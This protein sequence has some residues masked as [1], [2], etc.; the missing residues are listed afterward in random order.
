MQGAEDEE[1]EAGDE[2]SRPAASPSASDAAGEPASE[3]GRG[4]AGDAPEA[5]AATDSALLNGSSTRGGDDTGTTGRD[6][7]EK[8]ATEVPARPCCPCSLLVVVARAALLASLL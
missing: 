2:E 3:A 4:A 8:L 5:G 6:D 7:S 1:D